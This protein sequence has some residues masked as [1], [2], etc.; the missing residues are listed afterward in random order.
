MSNSGAKVLKTITEFTF[1][2]V[3]GPY[4]SLR[5]LQ[6]QNKTNTLSP[7]VIF[8]FTTSPARVKLLHCNKLKN[9]SAVLGFVW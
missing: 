5:T 6:F 1:I 2:G 9:L 8:A 4:H 3:T 7:H